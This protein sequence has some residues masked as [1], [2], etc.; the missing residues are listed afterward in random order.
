[1]LKLDRSSAQVVSVENYE[2][3]LFRSD[4]THIPKYLCRVSF[5]TI[6]DIYKNYFKGRHT[7]IVWSNAKSGLVYYSLCI[8]Y[9]IFVLRVLWLRSFLIFIVDE[10]KNFAANIFFKLVELVTYWNLSIIDWSSIGIRALNEEIAATIQ[11]QLSIRVRV[12]LLV[13]IGYWDSFY[14]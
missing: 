10:L 4:Y 5:H 13:G 12:Q 2:I 7:C 14:L 8:S 6:L 9:C 3:E 1:M 11:V